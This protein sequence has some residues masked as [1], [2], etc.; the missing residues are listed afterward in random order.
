MQ[1]KKGNILK[2]QP[3]PSLPQQ[4]TQNPLWKKTPAAKN[5]ATAQPKLINN[6]GVGSLMGITQ[7]WDV[8]GSMHGLTSSS[9]EFLHIQ[10]SLE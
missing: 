3:H 5:N 6:L 4:P 9:D 7:K 10:S 1:L 8:Q 2:N